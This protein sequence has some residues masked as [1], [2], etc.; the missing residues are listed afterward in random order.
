MGSSRVSR[1]REAAVLRPEQEQNRR[2]IADFGI[3]VALI[4]LGALVFSLAHPSFLSDN[5]FGLLGFIA[6]V[7]VFVVVHRSSRRG[8]ALYGLLYGFVAYATH[9]YWL[10][11]FHPLSIFIVPVIYAV[12]FAVLFPLL[13]AADSLFP[14]HGYLVQLVLWLAY[15]YLR[16]TGF[17]GYAY[18]ISGYTMYRFP[19]FIAVSDIFGVWG[20]SALVLFPSVLLGDAL[21]NGWEGAR[22]VLYGRRVHAAVYGV[23]VIASLAYGVVTRVDYSQSRMWRVALVQQNVDPWQ[24]GVTAYRQSL[25]ILIRQSR[26]AMEHDP[27]IV[28]WSETSFVPSINFHTRFRTDPESFALVR[29]LITFL[30]AQD[31]PFVIGNSDGRMVRRAD[32]SMERADYNA[33]LL[34]ENGAV[35]DTYRKIHLVPFT[36]HFP[37]QRVFPWLYR[38]LV[39]NE[40]TFWEAGDEYVI[41][42]AG[43]VRFGTPIC[44]EDTFGY[45]SRNFVREGAEVLVNLTNDSWADSVAAAM[46]HMAMAVF[47]AT[48]NRR[49]MVRSTNGGMTTIIDPN[50]KILDLFPAFVEGY[51]IGEAPVYTDRTTIYT[52]FGDWFAWL[53]VGLAPVLLLAGA[54]G[55]L[56]RRR[57]SA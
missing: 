20:V 36:E 9:N 15:E 44:F 54:G 5:G 34:F 21:K 38:L 52:R 37:Y 45:L 1:P 30:S 3:Q 12:Y 13:K 7:P 32:G 19:T 35:V 41:F 55:A 2:L 33:V 16:T 53:M 47:R 25:D 39:E 29:E 27:E 24:G 14:R 6:F 23:L 17:L 28:I 10:L 49:T 26:L 56:F 40:T 18:G 43:G 46:Q 11:N 8:I 22:R 50:G 57:Q 4:F 31:L 42:E 51:L 48:E